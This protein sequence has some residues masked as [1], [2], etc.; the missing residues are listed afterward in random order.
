MNDRVKLFIYGG[1]TAA[2]FVVAALVPLLF[3]GGGETPSET[4]LSPGARAEIFA[5]Y[6]NAG[7]GDCRV[8]LIGKPGGDELERC[9]TRMNQISM[10]CLADKNTGQ[11]KSEGSEY[12]SVGMGDDEIRLCRAWM[13]LQSDWRT[14]LDVCFDMDSGDVYYFYLSAEC[15]SNRE[16]YSGLIPDDMDAESIAELLA[17]QRDYELMHLNWEGGDSNSATAI[18]TAEGSAVCMSISSTYYK[19]ALIDVRICCV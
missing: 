11:V 8:S 16:K 18:Y 10:L 1:V 5:A 2:V 14:W 9:S 19:T 7:G 4:G 13:E 6:W 3:R 15:V 17:Q 12:I